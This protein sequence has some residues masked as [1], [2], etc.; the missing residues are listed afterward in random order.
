VAVDRNLGNHIFME[1][2]TPKI[3]ELYKKIWELSKTERFKEES[4]YALLI[5]TDAEGWIAA[6]DE[7]RITEV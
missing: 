2:I 4:D 3:K 5:E 7:T 6:L 1:K